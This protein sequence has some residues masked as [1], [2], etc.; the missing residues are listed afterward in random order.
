MSTARDQAALI[1][2]YNVERVLADI[3]ANHG[4]WAPLAS[5]ACWRG[6]ST[7]APSHYKTSGFEC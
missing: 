2:A 5:F 7:A 1:E 6:R 3:D 4:D